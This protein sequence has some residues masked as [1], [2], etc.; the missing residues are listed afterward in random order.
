MASSNEHRMVFDLRGKRRHVVKVVYA[1]LAVLMAASLFLVVGPVNIGNLLGTS[2]ESNNLATEYE[3]KAERFE[4]ELRKN[5]GNEELL[6]KLT[7][8]RVNAGQQRLATGPNGEVAQTVESRTQYQKASAAWSEY[9]EATKEPNASLAQQ[10]AGTLFSLAQI[11]RTYGEADANITA[12]AEAQRIYAEQRPSLNSLS[13]LALYEVFTG[14]YKAAEEANEAAEA[15]AGSKFQR[16][17]VGNQFESSKKSAVEFQTK[18]KEAEK[19]GK[20]AAK[21][22][23]GTTQGSESPLGPSLGGTGLTE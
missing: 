11:S 14:N 15:K 19:A 9:L 2:S 3:Q 18:L 12:A 23:T 21:N 1:I 5:P 7:R 22:G 10:M 17:Q 4:A 8:T 6:A 13:T 16:E 20:E